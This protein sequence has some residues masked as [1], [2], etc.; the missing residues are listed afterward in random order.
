MVAWFTQ[1]ERGGL[2][3]HRA[4]LADLDLSVMQIGTAAHWLV[5]RNGRDVA[6]GESETLDRARRDAE[7]EAERASARRCLS[8]LNFDFG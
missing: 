4:G 6:E 5:T 2:P 7:Q 1:H 3:V 8:Q